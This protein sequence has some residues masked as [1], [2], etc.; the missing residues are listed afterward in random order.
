MCHRTKILY[1]DFYMCSGSYRSECKA[2]TIKR[3]Q[4]YQK[5]VRAWENSDKDSE[6]RREYMREYYAQNKAKFAAYRA[7]FRERHPDYYAEYFRDKKSRSG[8]KPLTQQR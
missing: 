5:R 6:A 8:P 2:C 7:K 1:R 3:N 4:G